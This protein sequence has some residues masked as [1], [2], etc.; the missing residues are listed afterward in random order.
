M[1]TLA[2]LKGAP[3]APN[4]CMNP[5]AVRLRDAVMCVDCEF[6]TASKQGH[7]GVCGS[8]SLMNLPRLLG[9]AIEGQETARLVTMNDAAMEAVLRDL[10]ESAA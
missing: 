3:L 9:G 7:C 10:V 1:K 6:I 8:R 2:D 4:H 5:D